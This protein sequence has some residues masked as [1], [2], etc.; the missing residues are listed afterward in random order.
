MLHPDKQRTRLFVH[1]IV[2][3]SLTHFGEMRNIAKVRSISAKHGE[4]PAT[5]GSGGQ[6]GRE[7][8]TS[9][10]WGVAAVGI[11]WCMIESAYMHSK[12]PMTTT[13]N[14]V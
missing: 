11:D 8:S 4:G 5:K 13:G 7:T 2:S 3:V 9:D 12:I 1:D 10:Y 14:D 6:D